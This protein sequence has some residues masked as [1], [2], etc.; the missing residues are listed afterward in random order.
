M[1][2]TRA[3]V[4]VAL[5]SATSLG[6]AL[7][8]MADQLSNDQQKQQQLN[9][10]IQQQQGQIQ[11]L[12]G[13]Q[14]QI[15]AQ[16]S[17]LAPQIAAAE[18]NLAAENAR[19]DAILGQIDETQRDLDATR[20][21]LERRQEIL[22]QR[23]RMLYKEGGNTSFIDSIFTANT[24]GD[25]M[26]RFILMR[27]ITHSDQVLVDQI[28]HD[29]QSIETLAAQ[30]NQKKDEQAATVQRIGDET[31]A[32]QGQYAQQS[33]LKG[34][35]AVEQVSLEQ[36]VANN[37][38]ALDSV[39]A[40]IAA[41]QYRGNVHSSGIFAWPGVQGPITQG[42]G[43]TDFGGE[44]PPPPGYTCHP[45]GTC[46]SSQGCFHYGID[47]AGP[48]GS[49][50]T[51]A[52]GGVAYTYSGSGGYGNYVVVVHANGFTSLYGHMS[53]F[54]VKS[55]TAVAKSQLIGYEGSTGFSSGPH[56]H[57]GIQLNG[58]WVNPCNYVGC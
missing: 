17:A 2:A 29:K 55:G 34:Q 44:P 28:K 21:R 27:D 20:I 14:A 6:N 16:L 10:Q 8:A 30:L 53:A 41:L 40:E 9:G 56:L 5:V 26:D 33:A 58:T 45:A 49:Q 4:L 39:N 19:L 43:C 42:F 12:Q 36:Q 7:G 37:K 31:S 18:A 25:L 57:F 54:A 13:Q 32:L 24:F 48:Y 35:L 50:I 11:Q 46:R 38:K 23:T 1:K 22:N 15:Q 51:A 47:I 3:A 52:D